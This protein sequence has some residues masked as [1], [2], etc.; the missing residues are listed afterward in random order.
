MFSETIIIVC[1]IRSF[2]SGVGLLIGWHYC[3]WLLL[4]YVVLCMSYNVT[5][6]CVYIEWHIHLCMPTTSLSGPTCRVDDYVAAVM[7]LVVTCSCPAPHTQPQNHRRH[8]MCKLT[9]VCSN[10]CWNVPLALQL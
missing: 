9:L 3:S 8:T 1:D 5:W 2:I 4:V 7:S 6:S 10:L